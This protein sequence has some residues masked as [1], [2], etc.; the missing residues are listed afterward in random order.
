MGNGLDLK[1]G[2]F[3]PILGYEVFDS[4]SNQNYSRSYGHQLELAV[5]R[6]GQVARHEA[7]AGGERRE[8]EERT[9]LALDHSLPA[10]AF[11]WFTSERKARPAMSGWRMSWGS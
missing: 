5:R 2:V 8:D 6:L 7:A 1:M 11:A 4:A 3:D 10:I 9:L